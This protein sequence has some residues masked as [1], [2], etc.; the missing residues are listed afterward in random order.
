MDRLVIRGGKPLRGSVTVSGAKNAALPAMAAVL[1]TPGELILENVPSL[2]DV[3]TI[4]RLLS[5]M[6]VESREVAPGT[7]HLTS[8]AV[9][10]FEV[11]Y[12]LVRTMRASVLALGPL[13]AR[14]GKARVS[15]PGGCAIG[16]RP[17]NL[18]LAGLHGMGAE[19]D[20]VE[21]YVVAKAPRLTGARIHFETVTVTGTE[22]LMMA[23]TL[24]KGTSVLENAACEPEVVDLACLLR[25]MGARIEGAGTATITVE[26]V[27]DLTGAQHRIIPDRIEAGTLA[28]AAA[29]TQGDVL[30]QGCIPQHFEAVMAK[31]QEAG[32]A[33]AVEEGGLR[34]RM[35][36]RPRPVDVTTEPFPGFATDM[37]AQFMALMAIAEGKSVITE[38][39]FENRFMHIPEISRMGADISV[40]GRA[41]VV[42]GIPCLRGAP[43]MATDLR[44]SASLVL[45][46]L[47]ARAE[48]VVHRIYH[49]DRGYERLE[50]KLQSLGGEIR[51]VED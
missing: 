47:Q 40:G 46:G 1:L 25:K 16:P 44:A 36:A 18:H 11:P 38:T 51:R 39:V 31:L 3:G 4:E 41:A 35:A 29:I 7:V 9:R 20:L 28:V 43:V 23:A 5:F 26:G 32:A 34:V 50:A 30:I 10:Q 49:L 19:I 15:L 24:A 21:G 27:E 45:A 12:D 42:R 33:V 6:G 48:T 17:I 13:L 14:F 8:R 22:N 37:Q 2:R